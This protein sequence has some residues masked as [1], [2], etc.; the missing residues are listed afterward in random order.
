MNQ[1]QSI[2]P[3]FLF[4]GP[5]KSGSTWLYEVLIQHPDVFVPT[6]KDLYFFDRHYDRGLP[7][8]SKQFAGS[9]SHAAVGEIS[10]DYI[11]CSDACERIA[12]DLPDVKLIT[13]L[14]EPSDRAISH[15]KYSK[16]FG[17]ADGSFCQAVRQNPA[18]LERGLYGKYLQPYFDSFSPDQLGVFFFND[19]KSDAHGLATEIF[20]FIG[21]DP[22]VP[23]D[24]KKKVNGEA[25]SRSLLLSRMA[26][27]SANFARQM[28]WTKLLGH[29]K[30]SPMI[31]GAFFRSADASSVSDFDLTGADE[32]CET[33][34]RDDRTKLERLLGNTLP[35]G[36]GATAS[37]AGD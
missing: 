14:R 36:C 30:R 31:R 10:H 26:K 34:Y 5:P 32:L 12:R 9:E 21:V 22:Q 35:W 13:M 11:Y 20:R 16:R 37:R 19:L 28:G 15:Y 17:N 27:R 24:V 7:W 8:Y 33:F 2:L 4:I 6:L 18:I 25:V 3:T 1:S 29:A 23:I